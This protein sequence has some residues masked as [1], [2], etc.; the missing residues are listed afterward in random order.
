MDTPRSLRSISF[1]ILQGLVLHQRPRNSSRFR[2]RMKLAQGIAIIPGISRSGITISAL[3]FRKVDRETSFRFSFLASIP[4]ILGAALLKVRDFTFAG[5][6]TLLNLT[7]GFL[8]SFVVGIFS[9]WI[10]GL[11][12]RKAKLHYFGYYCIL[13]ALVVLLVL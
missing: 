12:M 11:V 9:L 1:L 4:A 6:G 7:I 13:L 8:F 2:Y 5:S 3:L 10:L